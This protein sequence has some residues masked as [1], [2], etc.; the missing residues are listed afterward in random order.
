MYFLEKDHLSFSVRVK[1][2]RKRNAI[3]PDDKKYSYSCAIFIG[4]SIF[5]EHLKNIPYF[6]V[7][8]EKDHISLSAQRIRSYYWGKELS[9]F[10]M[11]QE[12]SYSSAIIWKDHL[13]EHLKNQI[14]VF[15]AVHKVMY[16]LKVSY[17]FNKFSIW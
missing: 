1:L 4:K 5:W 17:F 9:S 14:M 7:F 3:F 16:S 12:R 15:R 10:G 6:H 13:S 8:F 11:I 2:L